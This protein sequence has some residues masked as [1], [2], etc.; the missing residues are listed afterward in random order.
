VI[1]SV[2]IGGSRKVEH[3]E[4]VGYTA[5]LELAEAMGNKRVARLIQ[6]TLTEEERMDRKLEQLSQRTLKQT[7]REMKQQG[8]EAA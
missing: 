1:D 3:Y 7:M 5:A 6:Q 2:V 8:R 4:I